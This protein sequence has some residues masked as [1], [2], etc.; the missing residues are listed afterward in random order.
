MA[1][2]KMIRTV[3]LA[4]TRTIPFVWRKG[5]TIATIYLNQVAKRNAPKSS[6]AARMK[7][8]DSVQVSLNPAKTVAKTMGATATATKSSVTV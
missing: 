8:S 7:K 4:A 3:L 2:S 6:I 5:K 1:A